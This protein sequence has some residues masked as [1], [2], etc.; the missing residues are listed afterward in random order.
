MKKV[1]IVGSVIAV[2][3]MSC[4]TFTFRQSIPTDILAAV[5]PTMADIE[6]KPDDYVIVA[7]GRQAVVGWYLTSRLYYVSMLVRISSKQWYLTSS[8]ILVGN[9]YADFNRM[10]EQNSVSPLYRSL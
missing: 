1:V 2:A 9:L 6:A 8:A 3:L 10:R 5:A 7:G 4:A